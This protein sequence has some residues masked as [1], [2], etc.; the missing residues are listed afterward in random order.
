MIPAHPLGHLPLFLFLLISF[1]HSG[2]LST[3]ESALS[4][5]YHIL[6]LYENMMFIFIYIIVLSSLLNCRCN[7]NGGAANAFMNNFNILICFH[8]TNQG[9]QIFNFDDVK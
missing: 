5:L 9:F 6:Y 3:V 8:I 4:N 2:L 1:K 7:S